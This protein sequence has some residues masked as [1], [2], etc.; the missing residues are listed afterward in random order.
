MTP[1]SVIWD[2]TKLHNRVIGRLSEKY[3]FKGVENQAAKF[4]FLE[5]GHYKR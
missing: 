4:T 1:E 3:H 5:F 2:I